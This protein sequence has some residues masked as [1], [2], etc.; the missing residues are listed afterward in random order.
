MNT[1]CAGIRRFCGQ[2]RRNARAGNEPVARKVRVLGLLILGAIVQ[3]APVRVWAQE[4]VSPPAPSAKAKPAESAQP[5]Q[6]KA[7]DAATSRSLGD[8]AAADEEQSPTEPKLERATFGAGCFWHVESEFERLRGVNWAVSG[9]AGGAVPYPSY[10]MV[11]TGTTGHAEVVMVEYD[12]KVIPYEKLLNVFW[13]IHDPTSINQQGED[14]G[15]Q[16]RSVIFYHDEA[17]RKAALKSYQKLTAARAYRR[18]IVTDL[19][20]LRAF[21]RAEDY[22]QD[23]YGGK[24]KAS[25]RKRVSSS[26]AKSAPKT[27]KARSQ[28]EKRGKAAKPASPEIDDMPEPS[29]A[30]DPFA[31]AVDKAGRPQP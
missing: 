14:I 10:E 19:M 18:P 21:Y 20:P 28:P 22:H 8:K 23:Y 3:S 24:P 9:Y 17:Q 31:D 5:A 15:P 7:A 25:T 30:Q 16:Y 1:I 4:D 27:K 29:S 11:H 26:P 2:I 6:Q 13:K 12:P